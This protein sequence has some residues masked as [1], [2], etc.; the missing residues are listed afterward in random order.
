MTSVTPRIRNSFITS[1]FLLKFKM[2]FQIFPLLNFE[3]DAH[4]LDGDFVELFEALGLRDSI[5][6]HDSVD[7]LHVG[8][9][10]K[11]VDSGVHC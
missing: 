7:V 9:A 6:D 5:I 1:S 4:L 10:D 8:D 3:E 11:L 2:L